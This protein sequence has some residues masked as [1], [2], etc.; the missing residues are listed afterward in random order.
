M[1]VVFL[2]NVPEARDANGKKIYLLSNGTAASVGNSIDRWSL[3]FIP[4]ST[5]E[6]WIRTSALHTSK[7]PSAL[8]KQGPTEES[9][10]RPDAID[11]KSK[12]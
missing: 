1:F 3:V 11:F 5:E 2:E 9:A 7:P 12:V 8:I 4:G 10:P 6:I